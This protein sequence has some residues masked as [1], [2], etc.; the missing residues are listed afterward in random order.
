M[1]CA[2][3]INI[4]TNER[5][6]CKKLITNRKK[7]ILDDSDYEETNVCNKHLGKKHN[8]II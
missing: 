1:I 4:I 3:K 6:T 8:T 2:I 7:Q 5:T